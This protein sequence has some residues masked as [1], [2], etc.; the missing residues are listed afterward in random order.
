MAITRHFGLFAIFEGAP[1][2][3]DRYAFT[4][5]F[6]AVMPESDPG[7]YFRVGVSIKN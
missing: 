7:T 2:Q 3:P 6:A 4:D 5:P 1:F